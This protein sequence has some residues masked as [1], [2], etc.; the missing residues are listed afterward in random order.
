MPREIVH[1]HARKNATSSEY[2][3]WQAMWSRCTNPNV[4]GYPNYGGRGIKVSKRWEAFENFISDMGPRPPGMRLG[5]L[6]IDGDYT[7]KNCRWMSLSE[8]MNN[9]TDST[10]LEYDGR[11]M[12]I[13]D[14]ARETGINPKTISARL[15]RGWTVADSLSGVESRGGA[16]KAPTKKAAKK[17]G[18]KAGKARAAK[19]AGKKARRK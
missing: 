2:R 17:G 4:P 6:D 19:K 1:G 10:V 5:R 7:P 9:R 15:R 14:W 18:K 8:S 16:K 12:S 13:A 11:Q 3:T